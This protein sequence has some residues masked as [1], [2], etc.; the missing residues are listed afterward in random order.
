MKNYFQ[1]YFL[2]EDQD[3][4]MR[5]SDLL[6][7]RWRSIGVDEPALQLLASGAEVYRYRFDYDDHSPTLGLDLK[8]LLGAAHGI[9]LE[10]VFQDFDLDIGFDF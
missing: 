2:V 10:F 5:A 6:S 3:A 9:E 1:L 7:R 8:N 4:F